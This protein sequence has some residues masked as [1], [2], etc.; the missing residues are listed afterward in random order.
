MDK[1]SVMMKDGSSHGRG[2]YPG[3]N[4][5]RGAFRQSPDDSNARA[6]AED[7]IWNHAGTFLR[8]SLPAWTGSA[9]KGCLAAT[10]AL[11]I[12]NQNH[13]LPKPLSAVVSKVLFWPTLP[14]TV[15]RRLGSW[16]TVVDETVL[17][18]GAPFGFVKYPERLYHEYGVS[19]K[20]IICFWDKRCNGTNSRIVE[21][22]LKLY[23]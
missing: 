11:Y 20:Q 19:Q 13:L 16:S 22:L 14:I 4:K 15:T 21:Y 17:I 18:G 8:I 2:R 9:L 10:V 7:G 23:I 3:T 6:K 12:L 1:S 5:H